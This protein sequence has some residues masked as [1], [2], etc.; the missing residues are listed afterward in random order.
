V[1]FES[2]RDYGLVQFGVTPASHD[3]TL[4]FKTIPSNDDHSL[5]QALFKAKQSR[6]E[7]GEQG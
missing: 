1:F 3:W 4:L 5:Q 6:F 7:F 2:L